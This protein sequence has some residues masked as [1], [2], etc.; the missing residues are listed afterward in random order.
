[1]GAYE[2]S[3]AYIIIRSS[4][5]YAFCVLDARLNYIQKQSDLKAY[6]VYYMI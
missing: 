1:M 5:K 4:I 3:K 2:D 6:M